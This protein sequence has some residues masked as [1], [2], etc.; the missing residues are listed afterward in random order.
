M[1]CGRP[2]YECGDVQCEHH[3]DCY[4]GAGA[5]YHGLDECRRHVLEEPHRE[6]LRARHVEQER[7]K[8]STA[9]ERLRHLAALF[10]D[11]LAVGLCGHCG[12]T[13]MERT[14]VGRCTYAKPCGHRQGQ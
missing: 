9:H 8:A 13:I 7:A 11:R 4:K 3:K 1:K 6:A 12:A 10:L 5:C 14:K 2:E